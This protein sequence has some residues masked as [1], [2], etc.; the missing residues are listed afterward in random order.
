MEI[1]AVIDVEQYDN[2]ISAKVFYGN[3]DIHNKYFVSLDRSKEGDLG[4]LLWEDIKAVMDG[5]PC[6]KVR[7]DITIE[8]EKENNN[9]I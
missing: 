8:Q 6:N 2:G 3:Q 4:Q 7:I 9:G 5:T 1:I